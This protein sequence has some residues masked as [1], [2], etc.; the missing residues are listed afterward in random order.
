MNSNTEEIKARINIVDFIGGYV[1]LQ[2]AGSSWKAC[3]PFHGEKTPSFVVND[4]KQFWHCF[5]CGKGGDIF[6]FLM[7]MEGLEFREA[8]KIL[9]ER[10]GVEISQYN[11]QAE[12]TKNR[13]MEILELSAKFYQKQ[14][15]D[16]LGKEKI[17]NYL[18]ERGLQ[19][20]TVNAFQLGYAPNGWS[21]L[22]DFLLERGFSMEEISRT[23]VVVEKQNNG[24]VRKYYDR[25]RD[26]I[27]F[28]ITDSMGRIVGFTARVAPGGDESQA[29]YVNTPETDFYHKGRILY[30]IDKAKN[31]IKKADQVILVE[32]N[33]DVIAS[34]QA[35]IENVIAV[36]GT[37][38]TQQQ[39]EIIKR[40]TKNLCLFFDADSAGRQAVFRSCE[41]AFA[42]D[43]NVSIII[44]K[45]GK[46]AADV[47]KKSPEELKKL[48]K[49]A[50]GAM[51]YFLQNLFSRYDVN[52][53][54][55]KKKIV[56]EAVSLI[57]NF[58]KEIDK[59]HW[60]KILAQRLNIDE[61][62]IYDEI[63]R[64][65]RGKSQ[66]LKK[67]EV[68][69]NEKKLP[70]QAKKRSEIISEKILFLF[71]KNDEVWRKAE[72]EYHNEIEIYLG[73]NNFLSDVLIIGKENDFKFD[74]FELSIKNEE[75]REF[76]RKLK[77]SGE[78]ET[79]SEEKSGEQ[80]FESDWK[81]FQ[82]LMEEL[83]REKK[84]EKIDLLAKKIA[85]AEK[86]GSKEEVKRLTREFSDLFR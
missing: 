66:Y 9:A 34:F 76:L 19:E 26:R 22:A 13:G 27:V 62:I 10:A 74:R 59:Q 57:S 83:S 71:L 12:K 45:E 32:G 23:G 85:A 51:D 44:P 17:L 46:D 69:M 81:Y 78:A 65:T 49:E 18:F 39:I 2:K 70:F 80:T 43:L 40:Y 77:F 79:E 8:L 28:P 1:R 54:A 86:N 53:I 68:E 35:G 21:N 31:A 60:G 14:L 3:C 64:K 41:M 42:N 7:E 20:K 82:Q 50:V 24:T 72:E 36:S 25:F 11:A 33:M 5:G 16:G 47:V 67:E 63:S 56:D 58:P 37:A 61:K 84:K 55:E 4:E 30:G 6:T 73:E 52:N 29:K 38:L 75:M 15:W 48:V